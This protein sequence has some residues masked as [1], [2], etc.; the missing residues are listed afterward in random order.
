MAFSFNLFH[1]GVWN[2]PQLHMVLPGGTVFQTP[3]PPPGLWDPGM[4]VVD[5]RRAWELLGKVGGTSRQREWQL[6]R[7]SDRREHGVFKASF[8]KLSTAKFGYK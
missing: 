2:S 7:L 3:T 6:L 1:S 5:S 4:A 8:C